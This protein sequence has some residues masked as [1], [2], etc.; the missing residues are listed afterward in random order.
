MREVDRARRETFS[1]RKVSY[2]NATLVKIKEESKLRN[3]IIQSG[4][5]LDY[6]CV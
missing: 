5:V 6:L 2:Q 4:R 1:D 3:V